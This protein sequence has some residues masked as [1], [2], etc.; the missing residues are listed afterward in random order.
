MSC[1]AVHRHLFTSKPVGQITK[2]VSLIG[3]AA[4]AVAIVLLHNANK[5]NLTSPQHITTLDIGFIRFNLHNFQ[6]N[7]STKDLSYYSELKPITNITHNI[8]HT[9]MTPKV[10]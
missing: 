2:Q 6:S 3:S 9:N 8:F 4:T 7:F 5:E 1:S 10:H